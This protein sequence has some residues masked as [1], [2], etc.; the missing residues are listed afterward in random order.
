[1]EQTT[2]YDIP[3]DLLGTLLDREGH[4]GDLSPRSLMG[5]AGQVTRH[6]LAE[7]YAG[8]F[9]QLPQGDQAPSTPEFARV[10]QVLLNPFTN[11]TLRIW[12]DESICSETS[13]LFPGDPLEDGG[14]ILNPIEYGYRMVVPVGHRDVIRL[15]SP[16]LPPA[17]DDAPVCDFE[18]HFDG[19]VA[20]VLF[21]LIDLTRDQAGSQGTLP[22]YSAGDIS[23]ALSG[24][25]GLTKFKHLLGYVTVLTQRP[26]PPSLTEVEICLERLVDAGAVVQH[27]KGVF[28]LASS[29]ESLVR[30]LPEVLPG[31][32][33]QRHSLMDDGEVLTCHRIFVYGEDYLILAFTPMP[34]GWIHVASISAAALTDFVID[35]MGTVVPRTEQGSIPPKT[36]NQIQCLACQEKVDVGKKFCTHCGAIRCPQCRNYVKKSKFCRSCG[37]KLSQ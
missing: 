37:H 36:V 32:Q 5:S 26:H 12:T 8:G 27:D 13:V 6:Q 4:P 1:M 17:G 22:A 7:L 30:R 20:A 15:I 33:W 31:L 28:T 9:V 34:Q 25:W 24:I 3:R 11:M 14:V 21:G 10:A 29:L 19:P 18:G 23:A 2:F 16:A 35:E